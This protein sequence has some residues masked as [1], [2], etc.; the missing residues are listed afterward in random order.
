MGFARTFGRAMRLLGGDLRLAALLALANLLVAGL[1]FLDPVLFGRVIDLLA[2]SGPGDAL[3]PQAV[4]LLGLWGVVGV[5]GIAAQMGIALGAERMAHR[6]RL[7][8]MALF[9]GRVLGLPLAFHGETHS[10][11][12]MQTMLSGTDALFALWLE[13]FRDQLVTLLLVV[14]LL[15]VSLL[16]NWRLALVLILL[17]AGFVAFTVLVIRRT[18]A[19]QARAE[20]AYAALAGTAQDT[21]A[22][23]MLVQSFNRQP[24]EQRRFG[25]IAREVIRHQFPVLKWWAVVNVGARS[26]STVAVIAMVVI[27]ALLHRAGRAE[28]GD[29]VTFMGLASLLILRL[30]AAMS[31]VGYRF[32]HWP[33]V[34]AFLALLEEE[35][36]RPA[37]AAGAEPLLVRSGA[38]AFEGVGFAYPGGRPVLRDVSF[39]AHPG[40][41]VALVGHTGAGKTTC[42]ALLLRLWDP[43]QGRITIDGRDIAGVAIDSLRAAI[44]VVFQETML[45]NR[46]IAENLRIGRPEASDAELEQACRQADAHEFVARLEHGYETVLGERGA[47]LSGGQRQRLAIARALLK[48]PPILVLDEATSALDAASEARV[49]QALRRLMAGRTTFVIAHRLSTVREADEIL[50]FDEGHIVERGSFAALLERQG[51]FAQL[52]GAQ[53]HA[54]EQRR[55]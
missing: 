52:V 43:T 25:E 6:N 27:G 51:V 31:S 33:A 5:V 13:L 18:A 49:G 3:W 48:D 46:S 23:L 14:V 41:T 30:E 53:L 4:R 42:M 11:R 8:A 20:S 36:R 16:L 35:G 21:L 10:G 22:N 24:A 54:A 40:T 15:P 37:A 29:I 47:T 39:T 26:C 38:V 19:G 2:G 12:L 34:T 50:V 28:I 55:A 7:K 44:G 17:V 1:Q 45:L 9:Y 32:V